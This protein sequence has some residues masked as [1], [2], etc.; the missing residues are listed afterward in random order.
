MV[1][2]RPSFLPVVKPR[3]SFTQWSNHDPSFFHLS[4]HVLVLRTVSLVNSQITPIAVGLFLFASGQTTPARALGSVSLANGQITS[5][6]NHSRILRTALPASG[7][8][9]PA[10]VRG[11]AP[12][13]SSEVIVA[14]SSLLNTHRPLFPA[15]P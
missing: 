3:P 6:S 8:T 13:H 11:T 14:L 10:N 7:Q 15:E 1:K 2:T 4:N 9:T 12:G 5:V